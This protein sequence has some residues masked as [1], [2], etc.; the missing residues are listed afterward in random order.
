MICPL[1]DRLCHFWKKEEEAGAELGQAYR[2]FFSGRSSLTWPFAE[3][4]P[5][6]KQ[7]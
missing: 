5:L 3:C 2:S 7:L 6:A 1:L 4:Y